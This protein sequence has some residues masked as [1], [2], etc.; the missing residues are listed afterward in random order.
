[1][2]DEGTDLIHEKT[3]PVVVST[4]VHQNL[5]KKMQFEEVLIFASIQGA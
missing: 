1:M 3:L 5:Q 4:T 2:M